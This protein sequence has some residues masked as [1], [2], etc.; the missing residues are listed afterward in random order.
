MGL[1]DRALIQTDVPWETNKQNSSPCICT[2]GAR[3]AW[4]PAGSA[5]RQRAPL[6][7]IPCLSSFSVWAALRHVVPTHPARPLVVVLANA[8]TLGGSQS[9]VAGPSSIATPGARESPHPP[10]GHEPQ[11]PG[12]FHFT[13]TGRRTVNSTKHLIHTLQSGWHQDCLSTPP[14]YHDNITLTNRSSKCFHI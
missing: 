8:R 10:R 9:H 11:A 2:G 12:P 6:L 1:Q 3:P 4:S 7:T 13:A 14:S 5:Q